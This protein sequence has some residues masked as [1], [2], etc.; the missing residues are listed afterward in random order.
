VDPS[1]TSKT[2]QISVLEL[3]TDVATER[4]PS[5]GSAIT[6]SSFSGLLAGVEIGHSPV[7][8][9]TRTKLGRPAPAGPFYFLRFLQRIFRQPVFSSTEA[10][11]AEITFVCGVL[12]EIGRVPLFRRVG[13][14]LMLHRLLVFRHF[15]IILRALLLRL[16]GGTGGL[17]LDMILKPGV[18]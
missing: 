11:A 4:R 6:G 9:I 14:M 1:P 16:A 5:I 3:I 12:F 10:T 2:G 8:V 17:R 7:A 15:R 18:A 13:V